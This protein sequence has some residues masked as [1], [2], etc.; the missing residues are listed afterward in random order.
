MSTNNDYQHILETSHRVNW[1]LEDL[2][3][4]DKRLDFSR[5]FL[6]ETFVRSKSLDFLTPNE[7]LLLNH[8]RSRGYLALFELVE[9]IVV[10]FVSDLEGAGAEPSR[11]PALHN[12]VV[13]EEKHRQMF[14]SVLAEFDAQFPVRCALMGPTGA[15]VAEVLRHDP[16]A[17]T[18]AILGLEWMSQGH[19]VESVRDDQDLDSQFKRLLKYHWLEECQHAKLDTLLLQSMASRYTPKQID[20]AIV[21]YFEIGA[22]LDGGL[23][24]QAAFDLQ[25][26][27]EAAGRSL[28]DAQQALFLES[29]HRAQQ[30]TFIGT[31]M[32]NPNFLK[33]LRSVCGAAAKRVEQAAV[34]FVLN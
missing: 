8:I 19:Y 18:I 1:R 9:S 20:N 22:F 23:K 15:V 10:P 34:S 3:G 27:Q 21:E 30:W 6:P 17:V 24:Q 25:A 28:T 26:L 14:T 5:P 33:G 12:F 13:E 4:G 32:G 11:A 29:Q 2:V 31:A 7:K 16:L